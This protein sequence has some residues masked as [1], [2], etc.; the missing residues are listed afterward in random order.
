MC[1]EALTAWST[2][3][4]VLEHI[5]ICREDIHRGW[6]SRN[7]VAM[8][9]R[10]MI[11]WLL[12]VTSKENVCPLEHFNPTPLYFTTYSE[13]ICSSRAHPAAKSKPR[14]FGRQTDRERQTDWLT[15]RIMVSIC[16][17]CADALR[18]IWRRYVCV[19]G[20]RLLSRANYCPTSAMIAPKN[21][22]VGLVRNRTWPNVADGIT[23]RDWTGMSLRITP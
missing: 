23:M 5:L 4:V 8:S 1:W 12:G 14:W 10:W 15:T 20:R 2:R 7:T 11:S 6:N 17:K 19:K 18:C 21:R 22:P 3:V 9:Q 13:H 16:A